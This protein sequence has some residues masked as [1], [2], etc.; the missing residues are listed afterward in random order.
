[1]YRD[2]GYVKI[3]VPPPKKKNL[4]VYIAGMY[5]LLFSE[6]SNL[7]SFCGEAFMHKKLEGLSDGNHQQHHHLTVQPVPH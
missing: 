4:G 1:M 5:A 2:G 6:V 3:V 7:W